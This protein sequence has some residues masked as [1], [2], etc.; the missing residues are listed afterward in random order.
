MYVSE[1]HP[2]VLPG[3]SLVDARKAYSNDGEALTIEKLQ[4]HLEH[5]CD[6]YIKMGRFKDCEHYYKKIFSKSCYTDCKN[7]GLMNLIGGLTPHFQRWTGVCRLKNKDKYECPGNKTEKNY[8]LFDTIEF[9]HIMALTKTYKSSNFEA[10]HS[11]SLEPIKRDNWEDHARLKNIQWSQFSLSLKSTFNNRLAPLMVQF[12]SENDWHQGYT[13]WSLISSVTNHLSYPIRPT[14]VRFKLLGM[15]NPMWFSNISE[16]GGEYFY[17]HIK[18]PVNRDIA[19]PLDGRSLLLYIPK[20]WYI[21][22][23]FKE[24]LKFEKCVKEVSWSSSGELDNSNGYL[25]EFLTD[26]G[27]QMGN[28]NKNWTE[29]KEILKRMF[30]IS[31]TEFSPQRNLDL[32]L[33]HIPFTVKSKRDSITVMSYD[34]K[35]KSLKSTSDGEGGLMSINSHDGEILLGVIFTQSSKKA[36]RRVELTKI[37]FKNIQID[38]IACSDEGLGVLWIKAQVNGSTRFVLKTEKSAM[39]IG[40]VVDSNQEEALSPLKGGITW[41]KSSNPNRDLLERII[42][43]LAEEG[44]Y[45]DENLLKSLSSFEDTHS[46]ESIAK[47]VLRWSYNKLIKES[48]I[49]VSIFSRRSRFAW[50]LL[51]GLYLGFADILAMGRVPELL[52]FMP[53]FTRSPPEDSDSSWSR[54]TKRRCFFDTELKN[55][56]NGKIGLFSAKLYTELQQ[57]FTSL[58]VDE[59]GQRWAYPKDTKEDYAQLSFEHPEHPTTSKIAQSPSEWMNEFIII[60]DKSTNAWKPAKN[61]DWAKVGQFQSFSWM[62]FEDGVKN[63]KIFDPRSDDKF[64][65]DFEELLHRPYPQ[66]NLKKEILAPFL[67]LGSRRF[68][69]I[70]RFENEKN[71]Y[72]SLNYELFLFEYDI[73]GDF[74]QY[75]TFG[76][77]SHSVVPSWLREDLSEQ[78]MLDDLNLQY[79]FDPADPRFFERE[80]LRAMSI[81]SLAST[82]FIGLEGNQWGK[83]GLSRQVYQIFINERNEDL[84][85]FSPIYGSAEDIAIITQ[86]LLKRNWWQIYAN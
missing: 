45:I 42:N 40:I 57:D 43:S 19:L 29:I 11:L 73:N 54:W 23:E 13:R 7:M 9:S 2:E 38:Q 53:E 35:S 24:L 27:F 18:N 44:K 50:Y 75:L 39:P 25:I 3:D 52:D 69:M 72:N 59:N 51:Q 62:G 20:S 61:Y 41:G 66:L 77:S 15:K 6:G 37:D 81:L 80:T 71:Y 63:P 28:L 22:K 76:G 83:K 4:G 10:K 16:N 48:D 30:R 60:A 32:I 5:D 49:H 79:L 86:R 55:I 34:E 12:D 56:D 8:E 85:N 58:E 14:K 31:H 82:N 26:A 70:V 46:S 78:F 65:C 47:E 74:I 17:T 67:S 64:K 1:T 21:K 68:R 33:R 36:I 84:L